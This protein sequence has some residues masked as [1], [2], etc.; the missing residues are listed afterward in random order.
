[1]ALS[2]AQLI[3]LLPTM[4]GDID[5][6]TGDAVAQGGLIQANARVLWDL[7]ADKARRPGLRVLYACRSAIDMILGK[8]SDRV[9]NQALDAVSDEADVITN[10][11]QQRNQIQAAIDKFESQARAGRAPAIGRATLAE[12]F[13]GGT[14]WT[15]RAPGSVSIIET[16]RIG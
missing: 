9:D 13:P 14:P 12:I 15:L 5:P 16:R 4:V 3:A 11:V 1:M 8:L 10:R 6:D 7:H 2:E